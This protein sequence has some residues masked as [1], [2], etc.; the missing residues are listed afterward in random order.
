MSSSDSE[1]LGPSSDERIVLSCV[2]PGL[3]FKFF[4]RGALGVDVRLRLLG[5]C[6]GGL[7]GRMGVDGGG[8]WIGDV[9]GDGG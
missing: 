1:D 6:A 2:P 8:G 9:S 4:L 5:V 3:G 7:L